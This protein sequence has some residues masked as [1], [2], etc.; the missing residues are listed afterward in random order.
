MIKAVKG[1]EGETKEVDRRWRHKHRIRKVDYS[2][3]NHWSNTPGQEENE[4]K[5]YWM[6]PKSKIALWKQTAQWRPEK[7]IYKAL[8]TWVSSPC[9]LGAPSLYF[10]HFLVPLASFGQKYTGWD[11]LS[12]PNIVLSLC[13]WV[14]PEGGNKL[15]RVPTLRFQVVRR[16]HHITIGAKLLC[17]EDALCFSIKTMSVCSLNPITLIWFPHQVNEFGDGDLSDGLLHATQRLQRRAEAAGHV[18]SRDGNEVVLAAVQMEHQDV[19]YGVLARVQ[20]R[21]GVFTDIRLQIDLQGL[22]CSGR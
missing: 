14:Y 3:I 8:I 19:L 18:V 4:I 17:V 10:C 15:S 20:Q 6:I 9:S 5:Q 16:R 22:V 1:D 7:S 21:D 12:A 2:Y 13:D 11:I